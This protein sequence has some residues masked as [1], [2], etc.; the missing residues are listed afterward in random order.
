MVTPENNLPRLFAALQDEL[1]A[2]LKANKVIDHP[3]AKGA[4]TEADWLKVLQQHL[5]QRY[6][7]D[8]AIVID[9]RGDVSDYLD[10]VIYDRQYSPVIFARN[11]EQYIPAESVLA[12]FEVKQTLNATNVKYAGEKVASVRKLH[13]TSADVHT[14]E[15]VRP[16]RKPCYITGGILTTTA[17][18]QP[19]FGDAYLKTLSELPEEQRLDIGCSLADGAFRATFNKGVVT[20][21]STA[22]TSL[23][24][25]FMWLLMDLQPKANAP[26][27]DWNEYIKVLQP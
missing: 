16:G 27:I 19:A 22:N 10:I 3:G 23:V 25:F 26:A 18:W 21:Q 5:P 15:G 4:A 12:T 24:S 6:S 7:A 9:S 14:L 8:R 13:R 20:Q 17:D 11:R 2:G 1:L